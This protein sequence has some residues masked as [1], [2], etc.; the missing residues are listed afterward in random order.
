[1]T[2]LSK[3]IKG[4]PPGTDAQPDQV[5]SSYTVFGQMIDL[6]HANDRVEAERYLDDLNQIYQ[7]FLASRVIPVAGICLD[8]GADAGWFAIPFAAAFPKWHVICLEADP[9]A[10]DLLRQNVSQAGLDNITC[11]NAALHPDAPP[12]DLPARDKAGTDI[13]DDLLASLTQTE[14]A[15]FQ[16]LLSL[17]SRLAPAP[18]NNVPKD[19]AVSRPALP[20]SALRA[21]A[22]DL[23]KLDAPGCE[24]AI[25]QALQTEPVGFVVGRLHANVPSVMFTPAKDAVPRE[26][27]LVHGEHALRRDYEDNFDSRVSRLDIVVAMYNAKT[28]IQ[29][30]VD[31]LL[32]DGCP[33]IR[34]IVV[35]D[36]ST[37]G[38]AEF[39]RD[40]YGD[41]DRVKLVQKA[42]GG[43]A[44][45]R[46]FG[47]YHSD[48]T[49][50]AFVDADDRVDPDL[51]SALLEAARYTGAYVVE[52]GFKTFTV[53]D[54]GADVFE[55]SYEAKYYT[56]PGHHYLGDY[57]YDWVDGTQIMI[58]QPTIWRRVH[59]RDFLD[60][61]DIWF[62]EHVRA[63]DDQMFQLLVGQY[64]TAIAHVHGIHYHYRQHPAQDI[65]QG[66]ERHF[67]SFNMFRN[68]FL[69]ALDEGW[70][71][72]LPTVGSLINT[73]HWSYSGLRDDLKPVYAEAAA[74]FLVT[75]Q[76]TFGDVLDADHINRTGIQGLDALVQHKLASMENT[77][78]SHGMMR[79]ESW[80]WQP[81]F[82]RMMQSLDQKTHP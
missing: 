20:L 6:A 57:D 48:V 42:N 36:G 26:H 51:F 46:N 17:G 35:D 25:G 53:D 34:V 29:E 12:L 39:V 2:L 31:S 61:K 78:I 71:D 77:P 1:M 81:E 19:H 13:S 76:K 40:L 50:I 11:I 66:D 10:F 43:C 49:H 24:A 72:I 28:F 44:S 33:D 15:V 63:F 69:R 8:I 73:M 59:R 58:G 38:S 22:P 80:R 70:N 9:S 74:E 55:P 67:Y 27:Y 32:A 62:P 45:A 23:I 37:D 41:N 60:R 4:A 3:L 56:Q 16:R 54:Q 5:T 21:I 52:G 18:S 47:R 7:P 64:A 79:L 14:T 68:I 75:V 30:C 82:I 65:K